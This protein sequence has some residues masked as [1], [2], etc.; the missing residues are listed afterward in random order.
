MI[1]PVT[2]W[3]YKIYQNKGFILAM[4]KKRLHKIRDSFESI[5]IKI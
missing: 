4:R 5:G 1:T 3:W 2:D